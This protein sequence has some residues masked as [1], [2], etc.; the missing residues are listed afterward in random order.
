[1]DTIAGYTKIF[2]AYGNAG[3]NVHVVNSDYEE[4]EKI[5]KLYRSNYRYTT[6]YR[7]ILTLNADPA[8]G[9]R[10]NPAGDIKTIEKEGVKIIYKTFDKLILIDSLIIKGP[11]ENLKSGLY[12]VKYERNGWRTLDSDRLDAI[13][14]KHKW[15][16]KDGSSHYAAISGKFDNAEYAGK[17]LSEHLVQA[18]YKN[19]SFV[20]TDVEK[21]GNHFSM[22]WM[23][24]GQHKTKTCANELA[25]IIQQSAKANIPVNWLVHGEGANTFKAAAEIIKSQPLATVGQQKMY[26]KE[27]FTMGQKVYFSNPSISSKNKLQTLCAEAGLQY[28]GLNTN[29]RDLRNFGTLRNVGV[30]LGKAVVTTVGTGGAISGATALGQAGLDNAGKAF[31]T[32]AD[33]ISSG[34]I[35]RSSAALLAVGV[36]AFG[37]FKKSQSVRASWKCTF[38]TGNQRWYTDDKTLLNV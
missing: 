36:M 5:K 2:S 30:E 21:P 31:Q 10:K 4:F 11:L 25:S 34:D 17:M 8:R 9:E 15:K 32:M 7:L 13:D 29:N 23:E 3:R 19:Q 24:K 35:L 22:Y 6:I 28:V 26:P 20:P 14:G 1:M 16:D 37:A 12:A 27:T 38:G 33:S 18:Y